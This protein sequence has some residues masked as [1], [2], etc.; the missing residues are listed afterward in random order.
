ML[1]QQG[2]KQ[3]L[4]GQLGDRMMGAH[5][6]HLGIGLG[7]SLLIAVVVAHQQPELIVLV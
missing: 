6:A 5:T 3:R 7:Q 4:I 2:G 1:L